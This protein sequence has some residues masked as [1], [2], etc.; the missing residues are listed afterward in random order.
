[1]VVRWIEE[2]IS[3]RISRIHVGGEHS[4][5]ILMHSGVP[6]GFMIGPL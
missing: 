3:D 5:S 1:M 4:G 6:Q 2:Y